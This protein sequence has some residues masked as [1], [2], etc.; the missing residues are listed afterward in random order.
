MLGV[1]LPVHVFAL[2]HHNP[3]K[4]KIGLSIKIVI[5]LNIYSIKYFRWKTK[6][7]RACVMLVTGWIMVIKSHVV[8]PSSGS[9]KAVNVIHHDIYG[10]QLLN[11]RY[12]ADMLAENGYMHEHYL[13]YKH[14][15]RNKHYIRS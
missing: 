7:S 15:H 11:T 10:W 2:V 14:I 8:K 12:M 4:K 13:S 1:F 9:D 6:Q 3:L 5:I